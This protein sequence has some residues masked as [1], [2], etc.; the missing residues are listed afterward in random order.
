MMLVP[1]GGSKIPVQRLRTGA[2]AP[3]EHVIT[4]VREVSPLAPAA[5]GHPGGGPPAADG[6]GEECGGCGRF[7][8]GGQRRR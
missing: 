8:R 3:P 1:S 7:K 6:P 5:G 2:A 4:A